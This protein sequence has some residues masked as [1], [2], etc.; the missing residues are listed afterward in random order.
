M[1]WVSQSVSTLANGQ[2]PSK[3]D[4]ESRQGFV[5]GSETWISHLSAVRYVSSP[6]HCA[7]Q[8][9]LV[10]R[11]GLHA[12]PPSYYIQA[13]KMVSEY[14]AASRTVRDTRTTSMPLPI[15]CR[16]H[17]IAGLLSAASG[18]RQGRVPARVFI[19]P[20]RPTLPEEVTNHAFPRSLLRTCVHTGH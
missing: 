5:G 13:R 19:C 18:R 15:Q 9:L 4:A 10:L 3:R 6:A 12:F 7:T 2:G 1:A 17:R 14:P 20:A 8:T 16:V 11:F